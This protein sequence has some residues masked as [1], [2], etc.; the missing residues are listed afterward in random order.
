M[1]PADSLTV[2]DFRYLDRQCGSRVFRAPRI[3]S[4]Q[5]QE[6]PLDRYLGQLSFS[7]KLPLRSDWTVLHHDCGCRRSGNDGEWNCRGE[8]RITQFADRLRPPEESTGCDA[9]WSCSH[10]YVVPCNACRWVLRHSLGICGHSGRLDNHR[11]YL[12]GAD[13]IQDGVCLSVGLG[14]SMLIRRWAH[15][16]R[17]IGRWVRLTFESQIPPAL[18][19]LAYVIEWCAFHPNIVM[20]VLTASHHPQ[21]VAG[22]PPGSFGGQGLRCQLAFLLERPDQSLGGGGVWA[23]ILCQSGSCVV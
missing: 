1:A 23:R 9:E 7:H 11:V 5:P 21:L 17:T 2:I 20:V 13:E 15:T 4:E 18:L 22:R 16:D 19:A 12:V 10:S 14:N 8:S 6:N 3:R